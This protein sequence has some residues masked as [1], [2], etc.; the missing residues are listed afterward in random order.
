MNK[1]II[2]YNCKKAEGLN[3]PMC[4][5]N[6][7][8]EKIKCNDVEIDGVIYRVWS[9]FENKIDAAKSLENLMLNRLESEE[10]SGA[11]QEESDEIEVQDSPAMKL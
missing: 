5:D 9:S 7:D 4:Q 3:D 10:E 11:E 1:K 2:K 8:A 6:P